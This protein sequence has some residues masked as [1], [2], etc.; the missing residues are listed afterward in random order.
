MNNASIYD[1]KWNLMKKNTYLKTQVGMIIA[2]RIQIRN[3]LEEYILKAK[4]IL[5]YL[6]KLK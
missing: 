1:I 3:N 5:S 2:Y 4:T 6:E